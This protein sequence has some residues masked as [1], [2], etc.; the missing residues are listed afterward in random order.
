VSAAQVVG[1]T[2]NREPVAIGFV[3]L[4]AGADFAEE[5]LRAWCKARLAGY[6]QPK[7]IFCVEA[8]PTTQ[9]ANGTKIQRAK[10][11]ELAINNT[12]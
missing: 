2:L 6:K 4:Q 7:R 8:F 9:S 12:A 11:R 10:L 1:I 3:T 5:A